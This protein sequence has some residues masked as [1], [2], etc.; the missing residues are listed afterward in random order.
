MSELGEQ[1]HRA[2]ERAL[3]VAYEASIKD[4][5]A[6]SVLTELPLQP[7]AY[8]VALLEA[9]E[10]HRVWAQEII[11]AHA[12]DWQFDRMPLVDRLIMM[13]ALCEIRMPDCPPT[14]VVID[15][16]VELAKAYSTDGSPS[17][18]NGVLSACF[19]TWQTGKKASS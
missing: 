6:E 10:D 4:R 1:R 16:A 14:A 19:A 2:R 18:V 8:A 13:L 3:E 9:F 15:E 7:D 12:L 11:S 17:F 5:S